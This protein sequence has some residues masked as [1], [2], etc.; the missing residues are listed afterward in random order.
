M[1]NLLNSLVFELKLPSITFRNLPHKKESLSQ[2]G[3]LTQIEVLVV[4]H[5]QDMTL[6]YLF[7]LSK[8]MMYQ[9]TYYKISLRH[10]LSESWI[11]LYVSSKMKVDFKSFCEHSV[12]E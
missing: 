11:Y 10:K 2:I 3:Q 7:S 1:I 4:R 9:Q 5:W 12:R 6:G 8:W